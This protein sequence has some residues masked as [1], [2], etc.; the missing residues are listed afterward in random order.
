MELGGCGKG[1]KGVMW[2]EGVGEVR[3]GWISG[4]VKSV[5]ERVIGD[6]GGRSVGRRG[7]EEGVE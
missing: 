5:E 7:S 4:W 6:C 3:H 2:W 1:G